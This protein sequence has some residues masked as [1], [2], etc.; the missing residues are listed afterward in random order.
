MHR[1]LDYALA[2]LR[3]T[4]A[5]L[6][7]TNRGG[8]GFATARPHALPLRTWRQ[9][10]GHN[11]ERG[12]PTGNQRTICHREPA[13]TKIERTTVCHPEPSRSACE[14]EVE[15]SIHSVVIASEAGCGAFETP[16]S[17]RELKNTPGRFRPVSDTARVKITLW[18]P[19]SSK[20]IKAE[21]CPFP[22]AHLPCKPNGDHG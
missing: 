2:S 14:R 12:V 16:L 20:L 7:M 17:R 21:S 9:F 19:G 3:S 18:T 1:S 13:R 10:D 11:N 15:R 22:E 8:H 5:P 4:P 6:G